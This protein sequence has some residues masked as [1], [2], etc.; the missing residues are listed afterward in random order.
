M[1]ELTL[2]MVAL[3][4]PD[5]DDAIAH[6]CGDLGFALVEDAVMDA[7][8]RWVV[9]SPGG[10]SSILLAKAKDDTQRAAIGQHAGGRVGLF[11]H[12]SDFDSTYERYQS[13]SIRFL[14]QPRN[15]SFGKVVVFA[16]KYGNKWDLIE[17]K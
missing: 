10:G 16:D 7:E 2:A 17:P 13:A 9:V 12:T 3:V 1:T 11:L 5:Y 14:E 8:K 6:Y 15:E 4:V